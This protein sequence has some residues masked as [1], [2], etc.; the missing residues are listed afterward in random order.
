M[1]RERAAAYHCACS[2]SAA[3]AGIFWEVV[4]ELV[5]RGTVHSAVEGR[6][7]SAEAPEFGVP[8]Q[9]V[10]GD[11]TARS[12]PAAAA[13]AAAVVWVGQRGHGER[14]SGRRQAEGLGRSDRGGLLRARRVGGAGAGARAPSEAVAGQTQHGVSG[15]LEEVSARAAT[16]LFVLFNVDVDSKDPHHFSQ[17]EGQT[18][19]VERPAV[20]VM[21]LFI[22][23]FF[24]GDI[25]ESCRDV[26]NHPNDV[27][28]AWTQKRAKTS[29]TELL[30]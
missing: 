6:G 23:V 5:E 19:E 18:T 26:D 29:K 30:R 11:V 9:G 27:A 28:E 21:P 10:H 12:A 22:L 15:A 13:A 16:Q 4:V 24:G 2:C 14:R 20:G 1:R 3:A 8:G 17:D 25:T 7:A